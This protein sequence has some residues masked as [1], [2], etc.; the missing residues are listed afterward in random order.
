MLVAQSCPTLCNPGDCSPPGSSV[1]GDSPGKSTGAGCHALLQG[2][3]RNPWTEPRFPALQADSFFFYVG[4]FFTSWATRGHELRSLPWAELCLPAR[5][6]ALKPDSQ[7]DGVWKRSHLELTG[8]VVK[9]PSANVGD[10]GSVPESGR[11]PGEGNGNPLQC[12]CLGNP[13][14]RG[15]WRAAVRVVTKSQTWFTD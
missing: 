3:L 6:R 14:D 10:L 2:N 11:S 15:A 12:S 1:H 4:R 8:S 13:M 7:C 9:N 5:V